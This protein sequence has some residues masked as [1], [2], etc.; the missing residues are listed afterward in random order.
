MI[1]HGQKPILGW[2]M[3]L[4]MNRI[5]DGALLPQLIIALDFE[6][7]DSHLPCQSGYCE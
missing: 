5:R 1:Y 2:H 4:A 6:E 3:R 7:D